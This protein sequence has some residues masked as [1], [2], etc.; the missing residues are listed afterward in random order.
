MKALTLTAAAFA[1]AAGPL[2]AQDA[3]KSEADRIKDLER[4]VEILSQQIEAQETGSTPATAN[5]GEGA[6]GM[7]AAASKVY[8]TNTGLSV[9]GY[10]EFLYQNFDRKLQD[11]T[12]APMN[13]QFDTLRGVFYLGYKFNDRIVFNSEMEFEHSGYSDEHPEGEAILEFAYLDFLVNK[14]VNVRAGQ[15]L[16]PL[17]FTN[18]IHEPPAVLST[19]RP[20]IERSGGIIPTTWHENGVGLHGELPGDLSY[21][22]YLVEGLNAAK[23]SAEGISD[24]RQDGNRAIADR[25]AL[26]GRLDWR[27]IP[28]T[29]AGLSFYKGSS[30]HS[31]PYG[32][33]IS[34]ITIPTTLLD[35]HVEYKASGWQVRGLYART[36]LGASEVA[37]LGAADP[38][39][40]AGTR[41]WGGYLEAGY[42][43]LSLTGSKQSLIPFVRWERMN[44]QA[45]VV[46]GVTP[47]LANDQSIIT[48]GVSWKPIPQIAVKGDYSWVKNG[49]KTGRDVFSLALGYEF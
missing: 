31:D 21:R 6:F 42:D 15:V 11:G 32:A 49:A 3:S 13:D 18:E 43:A 45:A 17:G 1:L 26:T 24:G 12:V 39:F 8:S 38:A 2:F 20:F 44:T 48:T 41:Q 40:Q 4:K 28:G 34:A 9:G 30:V 25:F 29:T 36:T 37:E 46:A 22:V 10:G 35:A 19:S 16:L 14:A 47:D 27:P 33:P 23:F 5:G 7:G